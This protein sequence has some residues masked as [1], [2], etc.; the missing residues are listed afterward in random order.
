MPKLM[1]CPLP[2]PDKQGYF[3]MALPIG[4]K[5]VGA[6]LMPRPRQVL[7]TAGM[8]DPK[9]PMAALQAA[10]QQMDVMPVLQVVMNVT[11]PPSKRRFQAVGLGGDVDPKGTLVAN[12]GVPMQM[13]IYI[14]ELP[15]IL[16]S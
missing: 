4:A 8:I 9:N 7:A 10:Q 6:D 13:R 3:E 2:E 1:N 16:D 11:E 12:F 15:T 14:Y 5:I